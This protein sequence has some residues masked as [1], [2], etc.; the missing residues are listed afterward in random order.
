MNKREVLDTDSSQ[1]AVNPA[2]GAPI[3]LLLNQHWKGI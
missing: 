2:F 1:E 3:I